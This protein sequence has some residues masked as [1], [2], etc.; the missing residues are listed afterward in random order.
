MCVEELLFFLIKLTCVS[1]IIFFLPLSSYHFQI[2]GLILTYG[3]SLIVDKEAG[4]L[5]ANLFLSGFLTV[6]LV[7]TAIMKA[8]LKRQ[9]AVAE[10]QMKL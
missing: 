9:K 1:L 8:D 10:E 2:F 4:D 3:S 5:M 7:L 6:G